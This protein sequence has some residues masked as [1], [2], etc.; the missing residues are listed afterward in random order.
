MFLLDTL[1]T[2]SVGLHL[3]S[4]GNR[5]VYEEVMDVIQANWPDQTPE[6]LPMV[7]PS[8]TDAPK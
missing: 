5:I 3:S 6:T 8:W 1:L 4:A 2:A 7:F